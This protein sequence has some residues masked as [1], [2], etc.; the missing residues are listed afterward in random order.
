[1]TGRVAL[2]TGAGLSHAEP[3]GLPLATILQR[4]LAEACYV[5]ARSFAPDLV[6]TEALDAVAAGRRNLL[7]RIEV[8]A[9]GYGRS[10]MACLRV[11]LPNEAHLLAAVH[12]VL[13]GVHVTVNFDDG[14]ETAY[15]LLTRRS[16]LPSS[17]PLSYRRALQ[18]WQRCIPEAA[19]ALSVI[20]ARHDFAA[21]AFGRR[22]LL[23]K[24]HGS[25]RGDPAGAVLPSCT[26]TDDVDT[27]ELGDRRNAAL[28]VLT[29]EPFVVVTGYSG[30]DLASFNAVVDHLRR[31]RF[32]WIA[33]VVPPHARAVLTAIDPTQPVPGRAADALRACLPIVLPAW[34]SERG[35]LPVFDDVLARWSRRLPAPAAAEAFA[36][37]LLDVDRP[38]AA[39]AL[40]ERLCVSAPSA[41]RH[42]RLAEAC[43]RRNGPDDRRSATGVFL[44]VATRY[45]ATGGRSHALSR[46]AECIAGVDVP[47][48]RSRVWSTTSAGLGSL[49]ARAAGWLAKSPGDTVLAMGARVSVRLSRVERRL[50]LVVASGSPLLRVWSQIEADRTSRLARRVLARTRDE[51]AGGRRAL[52]WRQAVELEAIVALLGGRS[53]PPGLD[54]RLRWL[55]HRYRHLGE[56]AALAQTAGTEAL[57]QLVCGNSAA[58]RGAFQRACRFRPAPSG[59]VALAGELIGVDVANHGACPAT[60]RTSV[61]APGSAPV[62]A[63]RRTQG[64]TGES[65]TAA[66]AHFVRVLPKVELHVHLEGSIAPSTLAA[67]ARRHDDHRVPWTAAEASRWYGF[68]DFG[69]FLN[70]Y[71]LVC[72]QLRAPEEFEL[73]TMQLGARLAA[74]N[75]RHAEV[76]FAP[77]AHVRRGMPAAEL[78]A[79]LEAARRQ[80][81]AVHGVGIRWCAAAGTR[82]GPRAA[83]EM[84]EMVLAHRTDGVVSVG[85]AGL[86][87]AVPSSDFAAAFALARDAGLRC[88]VHAGEV[89]GARSIWRALDE[90]GADRIGHGIRCLED[91]ALVAYLRD[92]ATALEVC[93]TSNVRTGVV[94]S[95]DRHPLPK[96]LAEGLTVSLNTDDPAMFRTSMNREYTT[97][98]RTFGLGTER[99]ADIA[100]SAVSA[101]FLRE[102]Q[103]A[104]LLAE[105]DCLAASVHQS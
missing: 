94:A 23:V 64:L 13:G 104:A 17:A 61:L 79:V 98:A 100:R 1:M 53:P 24:L 4:R 78:F 62:G 22:P 97:V 28:D 33:P 83:M 81:Q 29:S 57:V 68:A 51:P 40:L 65:S 36:W 30:G 95:L 50:P 46:W 84:V 93:P 71:V 38:H 27:T 75:V 105:I 91:V 3:A 12:L 39:V 58:A 32:A 55:E 54:L 77:V 85:L 35:D 18:A 73:V 19:P 102:Q 86:E 14:V 99:L 34:P 42:L 25:V 41:G 45:P 7:A 47:T 11:A 15:A 59:V 96:L 26:V 87:S 52:L 76:T 9:P 20:A 21:G 31:G 88:V 67:L 60:E 89:S 103:K 92:S 63:R 69:D 56:Q 44:A 6:D 74:D 70:A 72:D 8:A 5:R 43:S 101:A 16:P 10:A 80:V 48:S 2:F 66:L 49:A 37:A 82:R 90:L